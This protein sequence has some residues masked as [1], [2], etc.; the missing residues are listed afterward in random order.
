MREIQQALS[1]LLPNSGSIRRCDAIAGGCISVAQHLVTQSTDGTRQDFFIKSNESSFENNFCCEWKGLQALDQTSSVRV[2]EPVAQGVVGC[3]AWLILEW[4]EQE[5]QP[6]NFFHVFGHQLAQLH[7]CT[8]GEEIGLTHNNYL[9]SSQQPNNSCDSWHHFF[10]SQRLEYQF[11]Q[12]RNQGLESRNLGESLTVIIDDM[13]SILEGSEPKTSLIHGD[14]WSGNYLCGPKGVPVLIDPAIYRGNRE[15]EFGMIRLFG[16]CPK[17]FYD[18]YQEA[19]PFS[20]GW[21]RRTDV[22]LLYHL[23]NHLNLFGTG[24]LA[25]CERVARAILANR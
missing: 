1:N 21:E 19:F 7:R 22:Y 3:K 9:G 6:A 15:A 25:D 12:L 20:D 17:S 24:Y 18:A 5:N 4:I 13:K 8:R 16:G 23:L 2:P 14:L 11:R 10:A